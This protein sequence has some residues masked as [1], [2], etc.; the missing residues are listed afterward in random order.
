MAMN[1]LGRVA[2]VHRG[3]YSPTYDYKPLDCCYHDGSTFFCKAP[4]TGNAP[5]NATYW[6]M[7]STSASTV[8]RDA[9]EAAAQAAAGSASTAAN[10]VTLA[11]AQV[12]LAQGH[13]T[14]AGNQASAAEGSA[15]AAANSA[16]EALASAGNAEVSAGEAETAATA[17]QASANDAAASAASVDGPALMAAVE[18]KAEAEHAHGAITTDGRVGT[19]PDLPLFTGPNGIVVARTMA[20][21]AQVYQYTNPNILHN[22]DFTNPV[23]QRGITLGTRA[24]LGYFYDRWSIVSGSIWLSSS[25]FTVHVGSIIEQRVENPHL[26]Y[27][28]TVTISIKRFNDS[29][30]SATLVVPSASD[31]YTEVTINSGKIRL[32]ISGTSHLYIQF[33]EGTTDASFKAIKLELGTVSTLHLDPPMD[34]AV[35]LPKCQRYCIR[36]NSA[37]KQYCYLGYGF[38]ETATSLAVLINLPATMRIIPTVA[39]SGIVSAYN[40]ATNA[41]TDV[42]ISIGETVIQPNIVVKAT[43]S[44]LTPGTPYALISNSVGT[45]GRLLLSA[46]L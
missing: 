1:N 27:G 23:N 45:P 6:V 8:D 28:R 38:A 20:E 31:Q 26:Y 42:A 14:T 13:A 41:V 36:L 21:A 2:M 32:G 10:Q 34:W 24:I 11:Q 3:D 16:G 43:S 18:G 33:R 22:W 12:S 35:E 46:D 15:T 4:T 37:G 30:T 44:G 7:M 29:I 17:A 19:T 9:A 40:G 39:L 25:Y 5:P